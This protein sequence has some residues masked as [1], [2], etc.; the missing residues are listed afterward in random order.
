MKQPFLPALVLIPLLVVACT[1]PQRD[2]TRPQNVPLAQDEAATTD[3][4]NWQDG[5][6][7]TNYGNTTLPNLGCAT[8]H[9]FSKQLENPDDYLHPKRSAHGT[10]DTTRATGIFKPYREPPSEIAA[11]TPGISAAGGN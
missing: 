6:H 2:I 8:S 5:D 9:N 4:P 10:A 7:S 11:G 3:C 1:G